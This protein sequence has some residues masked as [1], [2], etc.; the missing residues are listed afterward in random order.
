MAQRLVRDRRRGAAP[1]E[2]AAA[3]VGLHGAGRR[4]R[5]RQDARGQ[6]RRVRR[7]RLRAAR[8]R[9]CAPSATCR[10]RSWARTIALPVMISPT[11]V[12]AVHP[13][14]EVAV[15]RAAAARGTAMGLS[16]FASKPVEE[17]VAANPQ[18]L[19]PALLVGHRATQI[20]A[21]VER[22]K[23]AGAVGII[24]TLDWSFSH[25]RDWGSPRIPRAASTSA[26]M[27]KFAPGG[28]C[29]A[30]R[31]RCSWAQQRRAA[32]PHRAEHGAARPARA[33]RSSAR[34]ASGCRRRCRRGRTC[35][36]CASSTTAR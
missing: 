9:T 6:R 35:A 5:A 11:G 1:R 19:L 24:V 31:G 12:Q 17:V 30:R 8:R 29:C 15:A 34:T 23:A 16:S 18:D 33:R 2:E 28:R 25:G 3:E 21:R 22:A 13:D 27:A 14:G 26:T 4:L 32:R 10:R 20:L 36:G 7:A